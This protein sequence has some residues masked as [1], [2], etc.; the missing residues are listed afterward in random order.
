MA[1][2]RDYEIWPKVGLLYLKQCHFN[3]LVYRHGILIFLVECCNTKQVNAAYIEQYSLQVIQYNVDFKSCYVIKC[4]LADKLMP[5]VL[6]V[7]TNWSESQ[8][9]VICFQDERL[10]LWSFHHTRKISWRLRSRECQSN[11]R[12]SALKYHLF[13]QMLVAANFNFWL[14]NKQKQQNYYYVVFTNSS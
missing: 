1:T 11:F 7:I 2:W 5:S 14:Q 10:P 8:T 4:T 13:C 12:F 3:T 9:N 6:M